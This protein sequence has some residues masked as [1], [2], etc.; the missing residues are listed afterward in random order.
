MNKP[1]DKYTTYTSASVNLALECF[2]S[3]Q[4]YRCKLAEIMLLAVVLMSLHH[5][6]YTRIFVTNEQFTAVLSSSCFACISAAT[7]TAAGRADTAS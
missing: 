4:V 1:N 7:G 2:F 6:I 5:L 3:S